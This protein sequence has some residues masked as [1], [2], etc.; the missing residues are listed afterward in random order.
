MLLYTDG[1]IN[2]ADKHGTRAEARGRL[3]GGPPSSVLIC[4]PTV[5]DKGFEDGAVHV[6]IHSNAADKH[7]TRAKARGQ[8]RGGPPSSVFIRGTTTSPRPR[9]RG[10]APVLDKGFEDG[11]AHGN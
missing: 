2:A 5:L 8:L 9:D 7:G 3:R 4:G 10:V 11:A 1:G 6:A